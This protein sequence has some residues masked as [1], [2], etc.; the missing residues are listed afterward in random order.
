MLLVT[1]LHVVLSPSD[2]VIPT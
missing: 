1:K 2:R